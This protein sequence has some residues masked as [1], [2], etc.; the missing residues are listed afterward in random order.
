MSPQF[1]VGTG[2]AEAP[3]TSSVKLGT[4]LSP[5]A[6]AALSGSAALVI[7]HF[8]FQ[9]TFSRH[10][11]PTNFLTDT[12]KPGQIRNSSGEIAVN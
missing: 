8:S 2:S 11:I 9:V 3:V 7:F 10:H 6:F 5:S 1:R 4:G 12:L